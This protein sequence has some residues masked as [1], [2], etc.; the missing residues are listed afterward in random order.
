MDP[1]PPILSESELRAALESLDDWQV[2]DGKLHR[3]F[4]FR[5]FVDAFGFMSRAALC[6]ERM[7]HHPEWCNVYRTV[8]VDLVTHSAGGITSLDLAL[9]TDLNRLA[10]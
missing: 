4:V 3:T 9:A 2:R 7:D 6:A 10:Q 5:D 8:R 1:K